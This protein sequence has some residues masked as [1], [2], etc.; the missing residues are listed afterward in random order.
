MSNPLE[1]IMK[2]KDMVSAPL[3]TLNSNGVQ[4]Y[5][6]LESAAGAYQRKNDQIPQSIRQI[7]TKLKELEQTREISV[8]RKQIQAANKE[9]N[10]LQSKLNGLEGSK[11]GGGSGGIG[12]AIRGGLAIAGI[13]GAMAL[14]GSVANFGM[15]AEQQTASFKVMLGSAEKGKQMISEIRNMSA[16]TPFNSNDLIQS[17]QTLLQYNLDAKKILPTMHML[18][19]V[20]GGNAERMKSLTLAFGQASSAGKLQG[21]DLMQ[22]INAGFNPL[23]IM[24]E[25]IKGQFGGDLTKAYTSLKE[26]MEQGGISAKVV[27]MAFQS[28]TSK[29]G[30]YFNLM[31]EQSQT[32]GGRLSTL[33]E[34]VQNLGL[35]IYEAVQPAINKFMDLANFMLENKEVVIGLSVA[36]GAYNLIANGAAIGTWLFKSAFAALNFVMSINWIGLIVIGIVLLIT[37]MVYAYKKVEWFRGGFMATM[38]AIKGFGGV[39]KDYLIDRIKGLLSG[40]GSIANALKLLFDGKYSEA[41]DAAK[42]GM[43]DISGVTAAK[44][45]KY[46][47]VKVIDAT[48]NAYKKGAAEVAAE[49]AKALKG[50]T[51]K[52][53]SA[54]P[55]AAD[56][57][58]ALGA[59]DAKGKGSKKNKSSGLSD[60]VDGVTGNAGRNITINLGK[61]FDNFIVNTQTIQGGIDNLEAKVEEAMLRVVNSSNAAG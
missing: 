31:N 11:T 27:E 51:S 17:S 39:I 33:V 35:K 12:S 53:E 57:A 3:A 50:N 14:A 22:M 41:W 1:F 49:K 29:G 59:S 38:E 8:S 61:F 60:G 36:I 5:K 18:G 20:S 44:N 7:K 28:A 40:F 2:L 46:N 55:S 6:R 30:Q 58:A 4:A 24:A 9:I 42:K 43:A 48:K 13:G 15:Q 34:N 26:K 10:Q 25:K 54:A 52:T 37:W 19:D 45:A 47:A 23:S 16:A 32:T 56:F 21:Q